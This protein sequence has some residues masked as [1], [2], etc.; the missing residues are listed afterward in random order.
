MYQAQG[1]FRFTKQLNVRLC[2]QL[3]N[4]RTTGLENGDDKENNTSNEKHAKESAH[5]QAKVKSNVEMRW[6]WV[7]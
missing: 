6:C 7:V 5:I 3:E 2:F 1:A 4:L